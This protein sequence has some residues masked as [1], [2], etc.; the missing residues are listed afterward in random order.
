[1]LAI[2]DVDVCVAREFSSR[3]E[4]HGFEHIGKRKWV[5]SSGASVRHLL[6]IEALKGATYSPVWGV[7]SG[8]APVIQGKRF[9][10]QTT[11]RNAAMDLIIDPIDLTGVVPRETFAFLPGFTAALPT[12]DIRRCAEHFVPVALKHFERAQD[13]TGFC[14]LFLERS[15]MRYARF[16]FDMYTRHRI[17]RGFVHLLRG[18]EH[19]GAEQIRAFC[20]ENGLDENDR[21]LQECVVAARRV[22]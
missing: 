14:E 21:V 16:G 6:T 17:C 13:L 12:S 2:S 4:P 11:A 19:E 9:R 15:R 8:V 22:A 7:S 20:D 1:M 10:R 18:E 5:R 3:L